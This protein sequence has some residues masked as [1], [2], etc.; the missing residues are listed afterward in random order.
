MKRRN[1]LELEGYQNEIII[2]RKKL[3]QLHKLY[4]NTK[5]ETQTQE[6]EANN[7]ENRLNNSI[8]SENSLNLTPK[9]N[10]NKHALLKLAKQ[11]EKS[12]N[13]LK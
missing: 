7:I 2:L 1:S 13:S 8:K 3:S 4:N 11:L 6:N 5:K 9:R 12:M 10:E